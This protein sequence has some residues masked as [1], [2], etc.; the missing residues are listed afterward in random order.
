VVT[1][2]DSVVYGANFLHSAAI[3][4]QIEVARLEERADVPTKFRFPYFGH[5][6]WFAAR[7]YAEL[8][9]KSEN[10][11]K[12]LISD[13]ERLG[14][15]QLIDWLNPLK[16]LAHD[17]I[18]EKSKGEPQRIIDIIEAFLQRKPQPSSALYADIQD[19]DAPSPI[20]KTWCKCA[21]S[22]NDE[23]NEEF[24]LLRRVC[25]VLGKTLIL[26]SVQG[27]VDRM[28]L[29]WALVSSFMYWHGCRCGIGGD[30][31]FLPGLPRR[32]SRTDPAASYHHEDG[33]A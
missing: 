12:P 16:C 27:N 28:R 4:M 5:I 33:A 26:A 9:E 17:S 21:T 31:A 22:P 32:S 6:H 1:P 8:I 10:S 24:G 14:L 7:H 29:L 23:E 19:I 11:S 2:E 15:V 20:E 30:N 3:K 18:I 25:V 13:W